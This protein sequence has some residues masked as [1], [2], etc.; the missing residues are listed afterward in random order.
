MAKIIIA[1]NKYVQA[2]GEL[3]NLS[4]YVSEL[5]KNALCLLTEG[6]FKRV[7]DTIDKSF[8]ENECSIIYEKFNGECCTTE[9]NRIM[10]ICNNNN[11]DVI[12]GVGGGKILDTTK[13][14]G[15]CKNMPVVIVPTIASTDAPCSALSVIY[16]EDGVFEKYLFLKQNPNLVL[17][18]TDIIAQAPTR[19][20]ASG[21]GD[22]L[23]TYFEARACNASGSQTCAFG[24]PTL[25]AMALAEL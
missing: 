16:T 12:I 7:K 2:S 13:S 11:I 15:Y 5:G 6:G 24:T 14:V 8:S 10:E 22:A 21:M 3:A 25:A 17:V 18:D 9:I 1:P 20:L 4:K 19:L 23:A